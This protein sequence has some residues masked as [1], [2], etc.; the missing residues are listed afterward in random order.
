MT[1]NT[2]MSAAI[3]TFIAAAAGAALAAQDPCTLITSAD[4]AALMGGPVTKL[5]KVGVPAQIASRECNYSTADG[6]DITLSIDGG[7]AEFNNVVK[8][9]PGLKRLTGVGDAA[10]ENSDPGA[11]VQ[12][13]VLKGGT[14]FNLSLSSTRAG[15]SGWAVAMARTAASRLKK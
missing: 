8:Q 1:R 4:I 9:I 11:F 10:Y 14:Y 7:R 2:L 3:A 13:Y 15:A 6:D 5:S 12:V